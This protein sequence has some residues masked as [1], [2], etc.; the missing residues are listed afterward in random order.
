[1]LLRKLGV[2]YRCLVSYVKSCNETG[3]C[4]VLPVIASSY[5]LVDLRPRQN[6]ME[7]GVL[8][9]LLKNSLA[10]VRDGPLVGISKF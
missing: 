2:G 3:S 7:A 9:T 5:F 10:E 1:M 4:G 8:H 6:W